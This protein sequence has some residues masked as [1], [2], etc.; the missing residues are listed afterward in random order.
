MPMATTKLGLE[1]PGW[2]CFFSFLLVCTNKK[3]IKRRGKN[4]MYFKN[5]RISLE[6]KSI[7]SHWIAGR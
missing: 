1:F 7:K 2:N 5:E 3:R 4:G 6:K